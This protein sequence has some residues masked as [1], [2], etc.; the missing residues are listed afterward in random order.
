MNNLQ[1][2]N[3][4]N[5]GVRTVIVNNEPW[6][7]AKDV[8]DVLNISNSRDAISRLDND[9]KD[10]VGLTDT[11]GRKQDTAIINEFGVY[12][13]VFASHKPE[14]KEFKRWITHEVIPSIRK[15]G[16]YLTPQKIEEVLLNPDFIIRLATDL[17][18]ER[19]KVQALQQIVSSQEEAIQSISEEISLPEMRQ[20]LNKLV[21]TGGIEEVGQRWKKLY[22]Q[23]EY[24]FHI[25]VEK[26]L[27]NYVMKGGKKLSKLDFV[28]KELQMLPEL[29]EL[30]FKL[31]HENT[32]TLVNNVLF[33]N[34]R[35][36]EISNKI[37]K[38]KKETKKS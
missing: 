37:N 22:T 27:E 3:F 1:V 30:A 24:K 13:L 20:L 12:S 33:L 2:F 32:E 35:T 23:F 17:K 9:E 19:E 26:R 5:Y 18:T 25:N 10:A 14:A 4:K 34:P 7:V 36:R 21:R 16:A 15:H 6:F 11:I 28:E 29:Y 8:C 38:N 31:F